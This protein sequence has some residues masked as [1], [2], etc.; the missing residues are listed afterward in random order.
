MLFH[1]FH[2]DFRIQGSALELFF[3]LLYK[4]HSVCQHPLPHLWAISHFLR[5]PKRIC[6]WTCTLSC[7]YS[8]SFLLSLKSALSFT[9]HTPTS[10]ISRHLSAAPRQIP[11]LLLSMQ[12]SVESKPGWRRTNLNSRLKLWLYP[13]LESLGLSQPPS[14]TLWL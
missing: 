4:P 2:H 10:I 1:R 6:P 9:A 5:Y 13:L 7:L 12:K 11:D 3:I 14:Q 8:F